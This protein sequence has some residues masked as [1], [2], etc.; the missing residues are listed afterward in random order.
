MVRVT[1]PCEEQGGSHLSLVHC[2]PYM[3]LASA[4]RS[5]SHAPIALK[6][7]FFS[8][9][10]VT[11]ES[12][13]QGYS[14]STGI[15]LRLCVASMVACR[16]RHGLHG[17]QSPVEAVGPSPRLREYGQRCSDC[18]FAGNDVFNFNEATAF[19]SC[20]AMPHI[21]RVSL[22]E[23]EFASQRSSC[24]HWLQPLLFLRQHR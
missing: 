1:C 5:T 12:A 20:L 19:A 13:S 17:R 14:V 16:T 8:V 23:L 7:I 24:F 6:A 3:V 9:I 11:P 18:C 22:Q 2:L 21:E 10:F 4:A 15:P